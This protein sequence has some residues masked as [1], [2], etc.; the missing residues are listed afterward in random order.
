MPAGSRREFRLAILPALSNDES[1]TGEGVPKNRSNELMPPTAKR[2]GG[3]VPD[4][5]LRGFFCARSVPERSGYG[6]YLVSVGFV[7][8]ARAGSRHLLAVC[9]DFRG[10]V[11]NRGWRDRG[12]HLGA[13]AHGL[14]Q[15]HR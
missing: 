4:P 9:D 7:D 10:S 15:L 6:K 2:R 11:R 3:D 14:D 8:G 5:P 12:Q 1:L 13:A